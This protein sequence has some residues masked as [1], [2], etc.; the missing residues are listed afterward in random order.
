MLNKKGTFLIYFDSFKRDHLTCNFIKI[1]LEKKGCNVFITSKK[2]LSF[3]ISF[4]KFDYFI[5]I[6]NIF[7]P[8]DEKLVKKIKSKIILIDAEGAMSEEWLEWLIYKNSNGSSKKKRM[9]FIFDKSEKIF[10]WNK[11]VQNF[12]LNS[13]ICNQEDKIIVKGSLKLSIMDMVMKKIKTQKKTNTIGIIS[14]FLSTNDFAKRTTLENIIEKFKNTNIDSQYYYSD[15][16]VQGIY[17][18]LELIKNITQNTKYNI[19]IKP[20][21][22]ENYNSWKSLETKYPGRVFICDPKDDLI[23]W[24]VDKD[25]IICT[26]STSLVEAIVA[27]K[28]IISIHKLL[29]SDND[30]IYFESSLTGLLERA[31]KPNTIDQIIDCILD[32]KSFLDNKQNILPDIM[33]KYYNYDLNKDYNI[34]KEILDY[35][36]FKDKP[37]KTLSN[38]FNPIIYLSKN[39]FDFAIIR[40]KEIVFKNYIVNTNEYNYFIAKKSLLIDK[41]LD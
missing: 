19:N 39:F 32:K 11:Y 36:K 12:L 20:H 18:F 25:Q 5:I 9:K 27:D 26:P 2:N 14:R 22:N 17:I 23:E 31:H 30:R 3:S 21:P 7:S 29:R 15:G 16:E 35:L 40:V 38:I 28:K 37:K 13:G 41:V 34:A 10:V 24:I 1:F 8:F 4:L 33:F 6:S